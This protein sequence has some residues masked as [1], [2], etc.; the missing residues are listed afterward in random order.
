VIVAHRYGWVPD[1]ADPKSITWLECLEAQ[2]RGREILAFLVEK[3]CDWP[4]QWKESYRLTQALEQGKATAE[5]LGVVQRDITKLAEFK[6]WLNSLGIRAMFA[7]PDELERKVESA[8]REWRDR[9]PE[10]TAPPK[11]QGH[12]NPSAYLEYLREQTAWIDIR[13]LQVGTGKAYRFPI[14]ELYIPLT[15]QSGDVR[16]SVALEDALT[17]QRLVIV[18]DPGSGKTTFLR[19]L[20]NLWTRALQEANTD[21][22]LFP[23]FI[24]ISELV[25]H[26]LHC[27]AQTHRPSALDSPAWL[28]DFLNSQND[29]LNWGLHADFFRD[30]LTGGSCVLLLDGLDEAPGSLE[31][32]AVVRLFEKA[33]QTWRQCRFVVTTRP[34]SVSGI[35][36]FETVQIEPL[37]PPAIEKFLEHWCNSLF[38][39][40]AA[41]AN[42]HLAALR[43]ALRARVEI[44]R[45]AR[46][47]VMLTALAVV[48]W[49]ERR[50]PE[51]RAD[52]YESIITWL[53]RAR[54]KRPGRLSAERCLTILQQLAL[55]MQN[56]PKGRQVQVEKCW[57]ADALAPQFPDR[58]A[59]LAFVEQEEVDSGIIVSRG[60]EL[61]FWHLT[62]QEY[63]AARAIAGLADTT[64]HQLLLDGEKIYRP[65]WRE[66]A[67]LLAGV[68]IRQGQAKVEGLFAGVLDEL[69]PK[70]M[71]RRLIRCA[72]LL[73]AIV[74]DLRPVN[75]RPADPRYDEVLGAALGI[76]DPKQ[77]ATLDFKV[78][79][80][81][82]EALGQAGD[83]RL[84]EDNWVTIEA[85]E[86]WM[87]A[88]RQDASQPNYDPDA[89]DN[90]GPVR[91]VGLGAYQF[92]RYHVTVS[93]YQRFIN[94]DGY[95][96]QRWWSASG[97]GVSSEPNSWDE[98][99]LHP[100]RPVVGVSWY[101]ASAYCTWAGVRLPTE[102]EWERAA[103]GK[104][105]RKYP[106]GSEEPD[107]SRAN[108]GGEVGHVTPVGLYPGEATP[109]G[110]Q[111]LAGN[112]YELTEDRYDQRKSRVVRGSSF[113]GRYLRAAIRIGI[114]PNV[115]SSIIGFRC[116][117]E[118]IP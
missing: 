27:R 60:T 66:T 95:S 74:R 94:D 26:I 6:Q 34:G 47:P 99:I 57:A 108:L 58:T 109:D 54:E 36:G 32:E 20:A 73:G 86:F 46:N 35:A 96:E 105:G 112:A 7:N 115:R 12:D 93:E 118:L 18:G 37:E 44:R 52:L 48:H 45:M 107:P 42:R 77:A 15:S 29:E 106:W 22:L 97:F 39:E 104:E 25:G 65:E 51:Q 102:T 33:T 76:F 63:L 90:E 53:A 43:E 92:G 71:L 16:K 91:L 23:I 13:G 64:Q 62:F 5:L 17:H 81:A 38:P 87:G 9:H 82:A 101:E 111:D 72:G 83:P 1:A 55:A 85:G 80:E 69:G 24:R 41:S 28:I 113:G 14:E 21:T 31:R 89:A 4:L 110:I 70:L 61:R 10:F 98:Q 2:G 117:R 59:A 79:L 8:L 19:H 30:K 114:D 11:R 67:L 84:N 88:Q 68:L 49:N 50:L 3:D 103:R 78:R 75:Y 56:H 116:V 100:N 40:N